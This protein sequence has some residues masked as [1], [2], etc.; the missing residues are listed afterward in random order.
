[1]IAKKYPC[2]I[3]HRRASTKV[4]K[5]A[6][7]IACGGDVK[8]KFIFLA[9]NQ[10]IDAAASE[11]KDGTRRYKRSREYDKAMAEL[12]MFVQ[13]GRNE[14]D[15]AADSMAQLVDTIGG[16]VEVEVQVTKRWF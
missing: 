13:V 12:E 14:H 2:A 7:I 8:R 6:K 1:M 5:M 11:D 9:E 3:T 16:D 4:A 15:D 10:R